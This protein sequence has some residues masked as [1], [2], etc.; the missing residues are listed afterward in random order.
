MT[1]AFFAAIQEGFLSITVILLLLFI[2][3]KEMISIWRR[4]AML[5][6]LGKQN[7]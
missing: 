1:S 7:K 4:Y 2:V 5:I 6:Y 3:T